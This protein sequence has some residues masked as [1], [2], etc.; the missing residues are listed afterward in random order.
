MKKTMLLCSA[1]ALC[2]VAIAGTYS[3][4]VGFYHIKL[5]PGA[6]IIAANQMEN[7]SDSAGLNEDINNAF[8]GLLSDPAGRVNTTLHD[9]NGTG[10]DSY[11]YF[12]G[13]DATR[14]FNV[15]L[16]NAGFYAS[17]GSRLSGPLP[18][19]DACFLINPS[20]NTLN[21][22]VNGYVP[23]GTNYVQVSTGYNMYSLAEPFSTNITAGTAYAGYVGTSD[24]LGRTNDVLQIWTGAGYLSYRYFTSTDATRYFKKTIS[25]SGFFNTNG[26]VQT[27]NLPVGTGFFL[28]HSGAPKVWVTHWP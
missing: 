13:A 21:L 6:A 19:G 22:T 23:M 10:F 16:T 14:F 18:P 7:G 5:A 24:G 20:T 26:V 3:S 27:P 28:I 2:G 8:K 1:L 15:A 4:V 11:Q 17:N 9:W 12:T 25:Q